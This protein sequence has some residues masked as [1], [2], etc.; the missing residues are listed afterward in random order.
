MAIIAENAQPAAG[1]AADQQVFVAVVVQIKPGQPGTQLAE[2]IRQQRLAH[3][4]AEWVVLV[5]VRQLVADIFETR[6]RSVCLGRARGRGAARPPEPFA[7][8]PLRFR[9]AGWALRW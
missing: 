9:R 4:V 6:R 1:P 7:T 5:N 2:L 3:K 8:R